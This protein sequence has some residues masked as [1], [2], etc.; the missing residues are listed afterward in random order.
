MR[1]SESSASG[2]SGRPGG[3][4]TMLRARRLA[5]YQSVDGGVEWAFWVECD[6][7]LLVQ[8]P[9]LTGWLGRQWPL[10]GAVLG[11][12][13]GGGDVTL[14]AGASGTTSGTLATSPSQRALPRLVPT[15]AAMS[16][17]TPGEAHCRGFWCRCH[18]WRPSFSR[19]NKT[20]VNS[21]CGTAPRLMTL[22]WCLRINFGGAEQIR[23]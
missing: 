20:T 10:P 13:V 5:V 11:D 23:F 22:L 9:T 21:G 2:A 17:L 12:H 1:F 8:A 15:S 18:R 14:T 6:R 7:G 3:G 19:A 16:F 4:W